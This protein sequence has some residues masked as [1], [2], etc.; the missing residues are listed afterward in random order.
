MGF[1]E[2]L[3]WGA[4]MIRFTFTKSLSSYYIAGRRLERSKN[5]YG[6]S[7]YNFSNLGMS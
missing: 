1:Q 4:Q 5:K 7:G 2:D 6:K 3:G